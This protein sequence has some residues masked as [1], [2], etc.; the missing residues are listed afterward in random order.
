MDLGSSGWMVWNLDSSH[1]VFLNIR[2]GR[3]TSHFHVH[4]IGWFHSP[5]P[6]AKDFEEQLKRSVEKDIKLKMTS[7]GPHKDDFALMENSTKIF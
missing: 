5:N 4:F 6:T 3:S 1:G 2:P 7:T